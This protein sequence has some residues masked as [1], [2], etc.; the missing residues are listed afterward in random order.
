M[1]DALDITAALGDNSLGVVP[2]RKGWAI[3][4][5]EADIP[6]VK[7][8]INP[9]LARA[10]GEELMHATEKDGGM[11]FTIHDI[12]QTYNSLTTVQF[13]KEQLG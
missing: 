6:N 5:V 8:R 3:R 2:T 10:T 7:A 9:D 11:N 1:K 4:A 13:L 12:P